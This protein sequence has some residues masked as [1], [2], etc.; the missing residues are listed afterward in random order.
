MTIA[1]IRPDEDVP[2]VSKLYGQE[3][4]RSERSRAVAAPQEGWGGHQVEITS[5][6]ITMDGRDA[7]LIL[8]H[9]VTE[10]RKNQENLRQSEERFATAF[11]SS[12]LAITISTEKEGRYVDANDAYT[13]MMG[14][15]QE[16]IVGKTANEL[17]IWVD[18][19]DRRADGAAGRPT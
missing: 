9:D 4:A 12:P 8:A 2:K 15:Q 14:Y 13:K 7:E 16:E 19:E 11:R 10:Q 18:P 17:G 5:H 3:S 1:D 6:P